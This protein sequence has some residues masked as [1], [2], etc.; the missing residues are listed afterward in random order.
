M[1]R[2]T[3]AVVLIAAACGKTAVPPA[4]EEK[5]TEKKPAAQNV[6]DDFTE[7]LTPVENGSEDDVEI[8]NDGPSGSTGPTGKTGPT[9]QTPVDPPGPVLAGVEMNAAW[10]GGMCDSAS[11]CNHAGYTNTA[12]CLND[13]DFP[14]GFCTQTCKNSGASWICPD[15]NTGAGTNNT[16]T[17][18]IDADGAAKCASECDF[19]ISPTGCR[20]GYACVRRQ[21]FNDP[22]K[23]YNICLPE[24]LQRWP[25]E[26]EPSND[27]GSACATN[28]ACAHLACM[29]LPGGY[30]TKA[31]CR[32][33]GCPS[34]STC[35]QVGDE[36]TFCVKSCG[37]DAQCRTSEGYAC[38]SA[39]DCWAEAQGN[40]WNPGVGPMDCANAWG[41]NG[42][43]LHVC[44]TTK[45]DYIVVRKSA[46]NMALCKNGALVKNYQIGLG[47]TPTGDKNVEGDGKTP[48]G[49]FYAAS[50]IPNSSYYKAFLVSYPDKD[51]AT[52]GIN[53]GLITA[54]QKQQIDSAQ[55]GC[56]IPPQKTP[57]G[58]EILVHGN[59]GGSDWTL[60]CVAGDDSVLDEVFAVLGARDTIVILP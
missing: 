19:V 34:G 24:A 43:K 6:G 37:S 40:T 11:D 18:C 41:S 45:N 15:I 49:V 17:R 28:Q 52:R 31:N 4:P 12:Q 51:D 27:I 42:S 2:L 32:T 36:Q 53:A 1:K 20:P 14:N 5:Q 23:I 7:E 22:S 16:L 54:S 58:G 39:G 10:I 26:E 9:G 47:F 21:R 38:D 33:T 60:G 29:G 30:C 44:D 48:E 3:I 46:R 8:K 25:G 13:A 59:G 35:A 50:K 55:N 56:G 57:L